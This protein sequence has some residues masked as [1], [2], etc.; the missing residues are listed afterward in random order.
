MIFRQFWIAGILGLLILSQTPATG[1]SA[2]EKGF[3]LI[4]QSSSGGDLWNSGLLV[5]ART[6]DGKMKGKLFGR[7]VKAPAGR[8]VVGLYVAF[9]VKPKNFLVGNTKKYADILEFPVNLV[10]GR[11]YTATGRQVGSFFEVWI[12]DTQTRKLVSNVVEIHVPECKLFDC[13][14]ATIKKRSKL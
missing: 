14:R 3:A 9:E 11:S 12:V 7:P 5:Q 13:P 6:I 2:E 4:L 1:V 10:A 8:H